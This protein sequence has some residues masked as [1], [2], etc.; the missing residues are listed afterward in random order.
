MFTLIIG[1]VVSQTFLRI[2]GNQ[3]VLIMVGNVDF[4]YFDETPMAARA[5]LAGFGDGREGGVADDGAYDDDDGSVQPG[6]QY[7]RPMQSMRWLRPELRVGWRRL[8]DYLRPRSADDHVAPMRWLG[9]PGL[10]GPMLS[11]MEEEAAR[12]AKELDEE[13]AELLDADGDIRTF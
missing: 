5:R 3:K 1:V 11:E 10:A 7:P 13:L 8:G 4:S 2:M 6:P 9:S 12:L